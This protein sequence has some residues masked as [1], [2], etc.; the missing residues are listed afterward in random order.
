MYLK[1]QYTAK[2]T[3]YKISANESYRSSKIFAVSEN[4]QE[5]SYEECSKHEN[6]RQEGSVGLIVNLD[7]LL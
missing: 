5:V 1:K 6:C 3:I 2:D 7:F 4:S